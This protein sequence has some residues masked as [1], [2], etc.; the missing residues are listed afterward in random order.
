M[1]HSLH[2]DVRAFHL[3]YGHIVATTPRI[4]SDDV[5]RFRL[6]LITEE[7]FELVGAAAPSSKA[8]ELI[9]IENALRSYIVGATINVDLPD[10]SDA[11]ADLDYVVEGSRAVCGIDGRPIHALVQEANMSKNP[12]YVQEKDGHHMADGTAK[13]TKPEGW[14]PPD[15]ASELI[16]QGWTP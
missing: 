11:M 1:T 10:F 14:R 2:D 9:N 13:P 16:R 6:K 3:K 8:G 5:V 12:V 4:P 7:F 15:V